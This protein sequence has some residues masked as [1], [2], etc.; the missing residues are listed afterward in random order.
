MEENSLE[1]SDENEPC[2]K[3]A[4]ITESN[5]SSR[6]DPIPI[7]YKECSTAG[8]LLLLLTSLEVSP[9]CNYLNCVAEDQL[10]VVPL[11]D[12]RVESLVPE[13]P[14]QEESRGALSNAILSM[15]APSA[16]VEFVQIL[17]KEYE[18]LSSHCLQLSETLI[19]C[20]NRMNLINER[21]AIPSTTDSDRIGAGAIATKRKADSEQ[22][23]HAVIREAVQGF[24]NFS[25]HFNKMGDKIVQQWAPAID[26][27]KVYMYVS[28]NY[29][30]PYVQFIEKVINHQTDLSL[31]MIYS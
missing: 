2:E 26:T 5:H 15:S 17:R 8:S 13:L 4:S 24:Q 11:S 22:M 31:D 3:P 25:S 29:S 28:V 21:L 7:T 6:S 10:A 14:V 30:E 16:S 9:T 23:L 19:A 27:A 1:K 12:S 18:Q 20:I